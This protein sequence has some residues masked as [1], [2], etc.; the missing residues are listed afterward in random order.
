M[1]AGTTFCPRPGALI[2]NIGDMVQ[3]WSNGLYPAPVHRV[4]AMDKRERVSAPYFH[5]PA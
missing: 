2:V 5:N 1:G 4:L 3:V